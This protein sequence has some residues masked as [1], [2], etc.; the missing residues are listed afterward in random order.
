MAHDVRPQA[1][2]ELRERPA[3]ELVRQLSGS[4]ALG[5]ASDDRRTEEELRREIAETREELAETVAALA[6]KSDVKARAKERVETVEHS[7]LQ[8]KDELVSRAKA[9]SPDG[10]SSG[11]QRVATTV[12]QTPGALYVG[13]AL[14][15]GFLLGRRGRW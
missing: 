13:G 12:R 8:H 4:Q 14:L 2:G 15:V 6:E 9:A 3:A 10:A 1:D 11:A 5:S 7:A